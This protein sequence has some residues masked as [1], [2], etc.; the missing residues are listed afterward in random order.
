MILKKTIPLSVFLFFIYVLTIQISAQEVKLFKRVMS[1]SEFTKFKN[2]T[3]TYEEGK[4]YNKKF[5]GHG[6][7]LKPPTAEQWIEM[8]NQSLLIDRI[9]FPTGRA[10]ASPS[11]DNSATNWFPPIG[12][13]DGE[14]SCVSWASGYYVKTFQEAKEHNW[15][16]SSCLWEGGYY[17]YPSASY[18]DKIFS[19]DFIYHQV[20]DG[21]DHGSYYLDNM[22]LLERLGCCTWDRMPYN[23]SDHT[24]WPTEDAWRQAPWYRSQTGYGYMSLDTYPE[25]EDLKQFISEGNLAIISIN[26]GYYSSLTSTDFWT[27]D[28][29]NPTGTNHANT[30]VGYDDTYGPFTESGNSNTYGAFKVVNSWGE[31]GWENIADGYLYISYEC[32]RQRVGYTFFY[33]NYVN[34]TP[35]MVAVF[36]MEHNKRG[37]NRI[38]FGIG[39]PTFPDT[40]KYF[41]NFYSNGGDFPYPNNPIVVDITEFKPYMDD[42]NLFFMKVYDR[43]STTTGTI[44]SFSIEMYEDYTSGI[45]TNIYT[46]SE[47]PTNTEHLNPIYVNI[48]DQSSD[49]FFSTKI[50]L[51]G[52]YSNGS[53]STTLNTQVV[54]PLIQ[55]FNQSPWNYGGAESVTSI[56]ANVVDWILVELRTDTDASSTVAKRAGFLKSDGM[57]VELDGTSSLSFKGLSTSE[58]YVVVRHRNHLS[59][60]SS[61][62]VSLETCPS[63]VNYGNKIYSTIQIGDQ[64]WLSENLDIGNMVQGDEEMSDNGTIEKYCYNNIATNCVTYGGLYQWNEAMQHLTTEG[65]QGICPTGWHIPTYSEMQTLVTYANNEAGKLVEESQ[66]TS[67]YTA[68]NETGF[69]A[70]FTGY[71]NFGSGNFSYMSYYTDFWSS[72]E[73]NN[74]TSSIIGLYYDGSPV[75][76]YNLEKDYGF[77]VRC[78]KD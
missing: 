23:P 41:D 14:G 36:E 72:T 77:S 69:S 12:N 34:Y 62:L 11:H 68:T 46:S 29:Y 70:L 45:P 22:N 49:I 40:L 75:H 30:I 64:C 25:I 3:G 28:N 5:N 57:I 56:P 54:I 17:G 59:I 7:G 26:A 44:K 13:Q 27:L 4:N 31:G 33:E 6:T 42:V 74:S 43:E 51:E 1:D 24:T 8:K 2:Y 20:N 47:I 61:E 16:L 48:Y 73:S 67:G 76:F 9:E 10:I 39:V 66:T 38:D 78:L 55:P 19:P 52:K 35:E 32:M 50:F 58:H 63:N 71:R 60:M 21:E 15:D 37:E 18:Q 65:V 53:M